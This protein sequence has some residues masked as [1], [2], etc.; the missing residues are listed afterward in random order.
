MIGLERGVLR[1]VPYS[2]DWPELYRQEAGHIR[3]A[4]GQYISDVQHLGSTAVPGMMG[5]PIIDIGVAVDSLDEAEICIKPLEDIGYEYRCK[6]EVP[7]SHY[8]VKGNPSRYHLRIYEKESQDWKEHVRFRD[9]LR[10]DPTLVR[11]YTG[12]KRRLYRKLR[13]NRKAYQEGKSEF[14]KRVSSE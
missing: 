3:Q 6:S 13:G 14:I 5:K 7:K 9:R 2:D 11:E 1:L 12:L 4:I 8:L 10:Q